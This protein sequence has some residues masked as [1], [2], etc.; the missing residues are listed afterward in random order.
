MMVFSSRCSLVSQ[1]GAGIG[2]SDPGCRNVS[3]FV[4]TPVICGEYEYMI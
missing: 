1:V 4:L 2:L 3:E